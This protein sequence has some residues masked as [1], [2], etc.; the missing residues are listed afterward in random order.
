MT[1]MTEMFEDRAL[2]GTFANIIVPNSQTFV[3]LNGL[4]ITIVMHEKFS[5]SSTRTGINTMLSNYFAIGHYDFAKE[6]SVTDIESMIKENFDGIK[7]VR[8]SFEI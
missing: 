7:S 2:V 3:S 5:R 8:V 4:S 1:E 6:C